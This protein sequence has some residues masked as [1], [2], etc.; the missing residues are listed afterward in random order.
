[1]RIL[2]F[3]LLPLALP[4]AASWARKQE[5]I[6]LR[7]G[8]PLDEEGLR[9]AEAVGVPDPSAVRIL[10]VDAIPFPGNPFLLKMAAATGLYSQ[11]T[12][13][14]SLRYG[15]Y[16]R[17]DCFPDRRMVAHEC[18]HTAQYERLGGFKPF[19]RQYLKECILIGYPESPLEQEAIQ[20]S[21]H[22]QS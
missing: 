21:A 19:L 17:K 8:F 4:F 11:T 12:Q 14:L 7:E 5:A 15:I 20:R 13:G 22:L 1:M 6:I 2:T 18:V 9:D 10:L 16:I 3:L